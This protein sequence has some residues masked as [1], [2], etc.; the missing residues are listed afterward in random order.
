M[1]NSQ[2]RLKQ[3][4]RRTIP[5]SAWKPG[6]SGNPGGR[7]KIAAEIR[8]IARLHGR[9]AIQR[10]VALMHSSNEA[11]AVRAAEAL[12]DRGYGRPMQGIEL[13]NEEQAPMNRRIQIEFVTP[14][15]R[16]EHSSIPPRPSL[17]GLPGPK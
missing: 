17:I 12:L 6:Q 13:K 3:R 4:A 9:E 16:D 15:K 10:L 11:V 8:D 2:N 5:S 7:P 14:P 1:M